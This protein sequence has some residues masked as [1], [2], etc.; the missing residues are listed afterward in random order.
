MRLK[1]ITLNNIRSYEH[2]EI[3]FPEG[4]SL[5]SGDIGSGKTSILLG[6]EFALF[7]L[8]P[9][10]RGS[11]LLRNGTREGGVVIELDIDEKKIKIERTLK[12]GKTVSQDYCG[13]TINGEKKEISVVE[14]KN[15][16]LELLNYPKEFSKKQNILY[17]FTV[18]TPQE[19]MKQIILQ[20]PKTR[21]NTLRHV[22]GIDKYKKILEN[23]L[24]IIL[25]MREEKRRKEGATESLEQDKS[26]LV[27]KES[28]LETRHS[29]L[30]SI[31]K[32]FFS[33]TEL[34]KKIQEEKMEVSQKR[35]EKI[36][37]QQEIEK[38]RIMIANKNET[39]SSNTRIVEQLKNQIE[40]LQGMKF[41]ESKI[42]QLEQEIILR[43]K[44]REK[45]D[46]HNLDISSNISSIN[47][48]IEELKK[49]EQ[50][51]SNLEICPTCLQNVDAI[52][53]ANVLNKSHSDIAENNR[54]L[55]DLEQEKK[56]ISERVMKINNN[57]SL[58]EKQIQELNILKIKYQGI[59]EKQTRLEEMERLNVA[60]K[61]DIEFLNKHC[62]TLKNSVFELSKFDAIYDIKQ[63]EL[64]EALKQER[65][66]EIKVA[67]LRREIDV[68]SKQVEELK[69][70]IKRTEEVKERLNYLIELE[71]WL[72][73]KFIPLISFIEKNVMI[74]LKVEFSKLFEEWFCML[75]SD[76]FN[77][78]L[79]DD[80]TPIIE[81]QDYELDY[82]Y[83][84]GGERTAI[85]LAY[86]FSLN[87]VINSLLSKIKTKDVVILDEPTDGFSDQQLD[88]MRDVLQQLDVKQ[89]IIVSHEQKMEGFVENVIKCRKENGISF[90][91]E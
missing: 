53:R 91:E 61:K 17:K 15:Q 46:N 85:A 50:K 31:E 63:K 14:L 16:V 11:S 80:F 2:Q 36:R 9:G 75:V 7:G 41:D 89:L 8:Q 79:S 34:R 48:R 1:K 55:G 29:N 10:Q 70:R 20:D 49:L 40:E 57:I 58:I 18:Y 86:R 54:K 52:Y 3:E 71:N 35:E 45:S 73:T 66:S 77:I 4:S 6:V 38:T 62:E 28:D 87:K 76:S 56:E 60:L 25:K 84:S 67:E 83:L 51:I 82:S 88:K 68:F 74:K 81:L 44:D 27:L 22:F 23:T 13:I 19:E 59:H 78:R 33:K 12:K 43:K 26:N 21:I 65:L 24:T 32:D 37:L 47:S 64:E 5:L 90:I 39:T 72:T 42:L 30:S 69:E